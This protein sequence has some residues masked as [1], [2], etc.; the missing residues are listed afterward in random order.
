MS[1]SSQHRIGRMRPPRVQI[2]YDVE[3]GDASARKELPF[4]VGVLAD[5]SGESR[6]ALPKLKDRDF[7]SIDG[8]NFDDVMASFEPTATVRIPDGKGGDGFESVTLVLNGLASLEPDQ[9]VRQVPSMNALLE[10][11]TRLTDLLAKLDGN[12]DLADLLEA[13][14]GDATQLKQLSTETGIPA[15]GSPN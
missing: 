7:V 8:A 6:D 5:L 12:E 1:D 9:L 3:L 4:V 2:T 15:S 10:A 13:V 11:R 14:L